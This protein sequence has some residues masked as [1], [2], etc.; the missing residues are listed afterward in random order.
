MTETDDKSISSD[1]L[2][3]HLLGAKKKH[4]ED[5]N[6]EKEEVE[7][8]DKGTDYLVSFLVGLGVQVSEPKKLTKLKPPGLEELKKFNIWK[9]VLIILQ[10]Y[11]FNKV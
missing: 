9:K 7:H 6:V 10:P 5:K 3:N 11:Y 1:L 2:V 8:L 4:D